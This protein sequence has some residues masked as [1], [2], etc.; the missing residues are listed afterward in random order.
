[1]DHTHHVL[2][3]K[4]VPKM[5]NQIKVFQEI[6]TFMYTIME[7]KLKSERASCLLASLRRNTMHKVFMANG[8]SMHWINCCSTIQQPDT[9]ENGVVIHL[10]LSYIG[11]S[12]L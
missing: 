10:N 6:Q 7:E 1:M 4:Y 5:A 8:R 9:Q 3:E 2:N 12:K 11:R